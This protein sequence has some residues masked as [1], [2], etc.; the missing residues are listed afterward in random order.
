MVLLLGLLLG[1]G[2]LAVDM[3]T[4]VLPAIAAE[5]GNDMAGAQKAFG[6]F[7]LGFATMQLVYG[8]IGRAH[9]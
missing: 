9:V 6:A 3:V 4:P 8:Q 7:F 5:F 1:M 2:S